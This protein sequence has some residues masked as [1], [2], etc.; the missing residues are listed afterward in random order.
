MNPSARKLHLNRKKG[1]FGG[2]CAG[3]SD[4][5]GIE[6]FFIRLAVVIATFT[7][8]LT[9]AVYALLYFCLT[10][11]P[12]SEI[13]SSLTNNRVCRHLKSVDY[14]KRLYKSR[15][16]KKIAGVCAGLANY[17]ETSSF[18]I[19]LAFLLSL[20]FGPF[21]IFAYI[22][23]ALIMDKEPELGADRTG[24]AQS[25]LA[26]KRKTYSAPPVDKRD[27]RD[28]G[29]KFDKLEAK[30]RRLEATITSK[31]FKLHSELKRM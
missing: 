24:P 3:L 4:Y 8:P 12:T 2:V 1:M 6:P 28:C 10:D 14:G 16:D 13:A 9:I 19:R 26:G 31:K 23:A 22:I 30:L 5:L 21:A 20:F 11:K 29:D 25:N 17:F 18:F 15:R 27:I 7:W